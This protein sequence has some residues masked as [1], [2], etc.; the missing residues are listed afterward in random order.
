M[1]H[2]ARLLLPLLMAIATLVAMP[3]IVS[4]QDSRPKAPIP[5]KTGEPPKVR[6]MLLLVVIL[7]I[8]LGVQAIPSKRGHQD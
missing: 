7:G 1:N 8:G 3:T 4:A 6:N 2:R 5:S